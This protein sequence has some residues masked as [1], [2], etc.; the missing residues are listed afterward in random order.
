MYKVVKIEDNP[1]EDL[2]QHFPSCL[3]FISQA[4]ETGKI[5]VH[6]YLIL[7]LD[8]LLVVSLESQEVCQQW[9]HT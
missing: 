3:E 4:L 6:W 5:L 7:L 2:L 9:Q 8:S 1:R